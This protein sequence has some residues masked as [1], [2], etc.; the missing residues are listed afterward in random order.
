MSDLGGQLPPRVHGPSD[1]ISLDFS[2]FGDVT[3][4]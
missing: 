1:S 4:T 2:R 3:E